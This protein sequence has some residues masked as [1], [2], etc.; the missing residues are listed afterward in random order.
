VFTGYSALTV[1]LAL[2]DDGRLIACDVS[3]E[4][5]SIGRRYWQEAGVDGKIDL[6]IGPALRHLE[7]LLA[8][9]QAGA[10]TLSYRR[11]Q[12]HYDAYYERALLLLRRTA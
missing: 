4:W 10:S 12:A 11:G 9:G 3:E 2:P 5:T 6:R 8:D 7:A 1:A